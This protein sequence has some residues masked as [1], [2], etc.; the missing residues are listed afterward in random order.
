ME[1]TTS[2]S[3]RQSESPPINSSSSSSSSGGSERTISQ[4]VGKLS[5]QQGHEREQTLQPVVECPETLDSVGHPA[6]GRHARSSSRPTSATG[7]VPSIVMLTSVDHS[8]A[9]K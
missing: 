5:V 2:S 9:A 7:Q 6:P 4:V 3:K 8:D 1:D